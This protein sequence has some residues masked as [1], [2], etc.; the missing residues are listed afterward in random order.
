LACCT[1]RSLMCDNI[2]WEKA[3]EFILLTANLS[4]V[5]R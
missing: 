5:F 3:Q 2:P 1:G 4:M